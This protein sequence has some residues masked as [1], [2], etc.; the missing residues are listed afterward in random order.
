MV[1]NC[2]STTRNTASFHE[3]LAFLTNQEQPGAGARHESPGPWQE[4]GTYCEPRL[5]DIVEMY[6]DAGFEVRLERFKPDE[7]TGCI[8][9]MKAEADRYR[10][11]F[12]RKKNTAP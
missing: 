12:V 10:T 9:C 8:E 1:S 2:L 5:S 7:G 11:I 6:E 4:R 3:E